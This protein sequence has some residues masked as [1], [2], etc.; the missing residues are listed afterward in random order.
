MKRITFI[1]ALTV[2]LSACKSDDKKDL[3]TIKVTAE[4]FADGQ[5]MFLNKLGKNNQV[6]ALDTININN[7][8]A[9]FTGST[10]EHDV[11]FIRIDG[12]NN[13]FPFMVENETIAISL[14]KDDIIS[15]TI[16]DET[17]TANK[18]YNEYREAT[19]GFDSRI[20]ELNAQGQSAMQLGDSI[21]YKKL[22]DEFRTIRA[23]QIDV[24]KEFIKT[25]LNDISGVLILEKHHKFKTIPADEIQAL[26]NQLGAKVKN[27][28]TAEG[29][30]KS[31]DAVN[32]TKIGAKASNFVGNNPAGEQI[33]LNNVTAKGK[34]TII[35]FWASWCKPCRIENPNVV[36]LYNEYHDKGLEII[37]VS[38]DKDKKR[39]EDAIA[40]DQLT[41]NHVSNLM[42]WSDPIAR[43]YAIT[44]I[45]QTYILNE[46]GIIIAKNLRGVALENKLAELLP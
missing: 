22:G 4:G 15:S 20:K 18:G 5:K 30:R 46:D 36:R 35:D 12:E 6:E 21:T 7:S 39:W 11:Y 16:T 26:Y 19:K 41:W 13:Q 34:V 25:H 17:G 32:A 1:L 27:S 23:Q 28:R 24:E 38:L 43:Q 9:T 37:G 29:L 31:F 40:L 33:S 3:F 42:H 45:P 44:S 8:L 2:L 14:N 10:D